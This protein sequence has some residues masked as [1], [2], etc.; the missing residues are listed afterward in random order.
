ME[1]E[2]NKFKNLLYYSTDTGE[3][4]Q[5]WTRVFSTRRWVILVART[6][7]KKRVENSVSTFGRFH[8]W[9]SFES[10]PVSV[11]KVSC[12]TDV[13]KNSDRE[14]AEDR[15]SKFIDKVAEDKD[16]AENY[17]DQEATIGRA[18]RKQK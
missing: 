17:M 3:N 6:R 12:N 8:L 11:K 4:V 13:L 2:N 15:Y 14:D 18:S 7:R 10:S 1:G 16:E 5:K 9:T